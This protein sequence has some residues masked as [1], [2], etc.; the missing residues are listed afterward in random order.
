M[1]SVPSITSVLPNSLTL[2]LASALGDSKSPSPSASKFNKLHKNSTSA[3]PDQPASQAQ[4]QAEPQAQ[5]QA[6]FQ[7]QASLPSTAELQDELARE[8]YRQKYARILKSTIVLLLIAIA[9]AI[10]VVTLWMP[11]L[12]VYGTSMTPNLEDGNVVV[13]TK[14]STYQTGDIV[15]F[16]YNNKI[17][18]KRVIAHSGDWVDIKDDGTVYV[19]GEA[20]DEPYVQEKALGD[21]DLEFPYQVPE[22]RVFVLGDHRSVSVDSRSSQLGCVS[23]EQIVGKLLLRVW[24]I[25]SLGIL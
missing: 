6:D 21:C 20:I 1:M 15:G 18:I 12:R 7:P 11:V 5:A 24:P 13:L 16:Y 19:N 3:D 25:T 23:D 22:S 8:T 17:L 4:T 9:A 14:A 2:L 10:L